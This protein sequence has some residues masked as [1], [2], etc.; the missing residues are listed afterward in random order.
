MSFSALKD[1]ETCAHRWALGNASYP[2]LWDQRGYPPRPNSGSLK[3]V[4]VHRSLRQIFSALIRARCSSTK[5][6]EAIQVMR[7]L[8]GYTAVAENIVNELLARESANPRARLFVDAVRAR[9]DQIVASVREEVQAIVS[10]QLI[11]IPDHPV[12]DGGVRPRV[13]SPLARGSYP[14]LE[15]RHPGMGW[16]GFADLL[17]LDDQGVEIVDFKTGEYDKGHELQL[18]IYNLLWARDKELNP[19]GKSADR[20]TLRYPAGKVSVPPLSAIELDAFEAELQQRDRSAHE[21][22]EKDPPVAAPGVEQCRFCSVRHLCSTYWTRDVQA[23][24]KK[25]STTTETRF[26]LEAELLSQHGPHSWNAKVIVSRIWPS[27]NQVLLRINDCPYKLE[28]G[29]RLRILDVQ[30]IVDPLEPG[31][32]VAVVPRTSEMFQV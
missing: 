32:R 3:G 7:H 12:A 14:E 15:L 11:S 31:T 28:A 6:I 26:D 23:V 17:N 27:D 13:R 21:A 18:K 5:T 1:I 19:S 29:Q 10:S 9:Q 8:G 24:I 25:G 4:A 2:E 20:L 22:L 16:A 30:L